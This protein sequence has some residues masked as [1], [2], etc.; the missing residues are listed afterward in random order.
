M[1]N[2]EISS[3]GV[4]YRHVVDSGVTSIEVA[5]ISVKDGKPWGLP[6]GLVE[7]GE[8]ITRT[9]HREVKEETGLDGKIIKNLGHIEYFFTFVD[10]MRSRKV[11][12]IV[13]FFLMEY[14]GGSVED[15]DDEVEECRW[16]EIDDAIARLKFDDEKGLLEKAK[17]AIDEA[18]NSGEK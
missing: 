18:E 17:I 5:L 16:F 11:F 8:K 14:T 15:H 3:G 13:Y 9:A 2:R 10:E 12:K 4:V 1:S 6:K 7:K